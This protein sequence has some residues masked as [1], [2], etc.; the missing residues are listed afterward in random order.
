[1]LK[2]I[3]ISENSF[4]GYSSIIRKLGLVDSIEIQKTKPK[5][6]G[7]AFRIKKTDF[8]IPLTNL[9]D[10]EKDKLKLEEELKYAKGFFDSILKKLNNKNFLKNAPEKIINFEKKKLSDTKLKIDSL[11]KSMNDLS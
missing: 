2:L 10:I 1:M 3:V 7:V 11:K 4:V 6:N 9:I 8:I 5:A